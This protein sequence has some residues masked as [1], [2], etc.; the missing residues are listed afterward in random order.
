MGFYSPHTLVGDARRHGVEV[1]TPDINKSGAKA[2]LEWVGDEPDDPAF[3]QGAGVPH[4]QWGAGG[5]AVR[6]GLGSV[7]H[8]GEQLATQL[9]VGRPWKSIEDVK[10]RT[11]CS[12]EVLEALATAGA[13]GDRRSAL[14][15]AGAAA[16]ASNTRLPG[17]IT[18]AD[19]P[20]LPGMTD[21]EI[22]LANLWATGVAPD[23]HPTRYRRNDLENFGVLR[24]DE[25]CKQLSLIHI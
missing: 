16:Q 24:S 13:F 3:R 4:G 17:I 23:G 2:T 15:E 10:R 21:R 1:L 20:Q 18:G 6:L 19:A 25:L 11:S 5:P 12:I 22:A 9:D 7:R 8:V 14:W